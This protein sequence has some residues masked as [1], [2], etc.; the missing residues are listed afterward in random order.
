MTYMKTK[1]TDILVQQNLYKMEHKYKL[2][3]TTIFP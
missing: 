2:T 3:I 1:M